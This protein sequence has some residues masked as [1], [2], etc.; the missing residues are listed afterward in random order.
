[1]FTRMNSRGLLSGQKFL[2]LSALILL[3]NN[4]CS[5]EYCSNL[6]CVRLLDRQRKYAARH[7]N[8]NICREKYSQTEKQ[9]SYLLRMTIYQIASLH[10]CYL[11]LPDMI[12]HRGENNPA[13]N[14]FFF[15]IYFV[16]RIFISS[17][18]S[19]W[20]EFFRSL[21]PRAALSHEEKTEALHKVSKSRA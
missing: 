5:H 17:F 11:I 10:N 20:L 2:A 19:R 18:C 14:T 9:F 1:M 12:Y 7:T 3:R 16:F 6:S 4:L 21:G 13:N 8:K 15:Y